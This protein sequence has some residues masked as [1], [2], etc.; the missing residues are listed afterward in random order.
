MVGSASHLNL[1]E[2]LLSPFLNGRHLDN[3][4]FVVL[5]SKEIHFFLAHVII[6]PRWFDSCLYR[7]GICSPTHYALCIMF[8]AERVYLEWYF[9]A[10]IAPLYG[11][12]EHYGAE[13]KG[14][15]LMKIPLF[16]HHCFNNYFLIK[17]PFS[18]I[19]ISSVQFIGYK[20]LANIAAVEHFRLTLFSLCQ[21]MK[22]EFVLFLKR[23]NMFSTVHNMILHE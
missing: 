13:T 4:G 21:I 9:P 17:C 20:L 7:S 1:E 6:A 12:N 23:L 22:T 2:D 5:G 14:G 16:L 11:Q 10:V 18:L 8:K 15:S 3:W 19:H